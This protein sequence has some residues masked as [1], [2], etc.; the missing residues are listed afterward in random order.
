MDRLTAAANRAKVTSEQMD[1][2]STQVL[3]RQDSKGESVEQAI[4][5]VLGTGTGKVFTVLRAYCLGE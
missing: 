1:S 3:N 2:W 5:A 4:E